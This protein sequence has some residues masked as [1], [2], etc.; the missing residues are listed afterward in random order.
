[1]LVIAALVFGLVAG[2]AL[3]LAVVVSIARGM[4]R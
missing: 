3:M 1:M 2:A 4:F